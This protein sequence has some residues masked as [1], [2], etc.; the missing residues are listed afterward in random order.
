MNT[1]YAKVPMYPKVKGK[2]GDVFFVILSFGGA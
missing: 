2:L 1:Q